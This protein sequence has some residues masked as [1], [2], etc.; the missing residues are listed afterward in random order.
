MNKTLK[1]TV[2]PEQRQEQ[3][4]ARLR[5]LQA[6][7]SVEDL[8]S[9]FQ[10]SPL[11]IRRDLEQL[12]EQ[13]AV[14]RTHGGCMQK[15]S[16]ESAYRRRVAAN[17]ELKQAIGRAASQEL[18]GASMVL[19]NDGSTTFHLAAHLGGQ[20]AFSVFTN[21]IAMI[22]ELSRFKQIKLYLLG[23]E[24]DREMYLL[25]GNITEQILEMLYFDLVFLGADAIDKKGWCLVSTLAEARLTQIMLRRSK[26][27][28]LLAD[29][30][31][32]ESE[33]HAAYARLNDFDLWITTTGMSREQKAQ[34]RKAVT[35]K[36]VTA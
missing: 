12:E 16:I 31:K 6:E 22:S 19:I 26:R 14:V 27:K 17:F 20:G 4:L 1:E 10:V 13:G 28:I 30:T 36:E 7:V 35:I 23:G 2:K 11:T 5:A 34:F 29:H 21:S 25:G 18:K 3:I 33:S 9:L 8:A 32:C 24:F 15:T